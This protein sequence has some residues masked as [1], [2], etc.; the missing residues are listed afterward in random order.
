MGHFLRFLPVVARAIF[1]CAPDKLVGFLVVFHFEVA[2]GGEPVGLH[3]ALVVLPQFFVAGHLDLEGAGQHLQGVIVAADLE[4]AFAEGGQDHGVVQF[5]LL[6]V[7]EF[8]VLFECEGEMVDRLLVALI[9]EVGF[10]HVVVGRNQSEL[11]FPVRVDQNLQ[12]F[13]SYF[14][15]CKFVHSQPDEL[16]I[17]VLARIDFGHELVE[18]LF[19]LRADGVYGNRGS[20]FLPLELNNVVEDDTFELLIGSLGLFLV[21]WVGGRVLWWEWTLSYYS[22]SS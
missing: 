11:G 14:I 13:F 1:Y 10:A 20:T 16:F 7:G 21:G 4:V 17:A 19:Q 8:G 15:E 12:Y 3:V 6:D 9:D 2:A 5:A 18:F 22:S